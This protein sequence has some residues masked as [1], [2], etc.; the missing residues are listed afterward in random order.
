MDKHI[1]SEIIDRL[2]GTSEVARI[3]QIK[4]P[5]VSEWRSSGIPSAR[6]QFL[7]LLRP[8]VFE[9]AP[10]KT[11]RKAI[12]ALVDTRMSK[13]ALRARLGLSSDAHLAKV[14]KLPPADVAA[15]PEEQSVPA[16][17][18]VLRLLGVQETPPPA[19]AG[20]HDPDAGRIDL[21]VHAA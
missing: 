2:G 17:P 11:E 15:W 20:P 3:C 14:L 13:R 1:D 21:D 10:G 6:R 18:Q 16:L 9:V 12:A 5:S 19:E 8:D 7:S 4:P